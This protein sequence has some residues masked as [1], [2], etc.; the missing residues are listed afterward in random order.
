LHTYRFVLPYVRA[1]RISF[2]LGIA[3]APISAAASLAVPWITGRCVEKLRAGGPILESLVHG[4]AP[5]TEYGW[6]LVPNF[7]LIPDLLAASAV[8]GA[9]LFLVRWLIIGASRR[10]EYD[11]RNHLFRHFQ[12][13]DRLFYT[14]A[15]TGDLMTRATVDVERVRLLVGP[16]ILYA[17]RT[18]FMLLFGLPLMV[19]T[20][21]IL[22]LMV[23]VPLSLM[24]LAVRW[25]GPR[26]HREVL[27][28]QRHFSELSSI[29]QEDFSGIRVVKTFTREDTERK[30]FEDV[31]ERYFLQ[32][33]RSARTA[34]WMQPLISLVGDLALLSLLVVGGT[35]I[36]TGNIAF[37]DF[38]A[39]AGYQSA[40][41]WPML[42]IGWVINQY[43]R[44]QASVDRLRE[45]FD[46]RP[47]VTQSATPRLPPGGAISGAIEIRKL[48][49]GYGDR[50][51][52]QDI[53]IE[54]PRGKTIGIVG[55][56]GSGKS[57]LLQLIPRILPTPPGAIFIDGVDVCDLPL[58]ELRRAIGFVPQE[59]FLFS[60]TIADNI[61]FGDSGADMPRV[62]DAARIARFDKDIDQFPLGFDEMV[63]E[64]GV[65]LSGGQ[66]QRAAL[67]RALLVRPKIL[68]LDDA[69]S[70]VDTETEEEIL[71]NFLPATRDRTTLIA[72]HRIS[73]I[74]HAHRIYVLED[75]CIAESGTHEDL[76][77]HDGLYAETYRI[78]QISAEIQG[79]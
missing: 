40:L 65:T 62:H 77:R 66:K 30:R 9:S 60:R 51:V 29:A 6:S 21:W 20:S 48:S 76:I 78:Q 74:S 8:A 56:I 3:L 25:I 49:F 52:L 69:F 35:L 68:I 72:S 63:G 37:G 4:A 47:R 5:R 79:M 16:I 7:G 54:A 43:N 33:L 36:L 31:S 41:I 75:G 28:A 61:R 53:E 55:R 19:G 24:S 22:T 39:F 17:S 1:Y 18:I 71:R 59:G 46:T 10:V 23:M 15:R 12:D 57:T 70:A 2:A 64:R 44:A 50:A 14:E 73:T 45:L 38:V 26:V 13:L 67:A 42:S 11:L 58:E 32:S 27:E 34:A